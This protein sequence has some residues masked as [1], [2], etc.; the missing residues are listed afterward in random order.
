[1]AAPAPRRLAHLLS[2]VSPRPTTIGVA[3]SGSELEEIMAG[4]KDFDSPTIFNAVEK[5][6]EDT[7]PSKCYTDHT[8]LS[9]P[10]VPLPRRRPITPPQPPQPPTPKSAT[11]SRGVGAQTCCRS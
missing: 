8:I 2:A 3:A 6:T 5:V 7:T 4:L 9:A 1:M 11:H 10:A